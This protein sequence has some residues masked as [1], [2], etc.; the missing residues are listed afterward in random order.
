MRRK[1]LKK[2]LVLWYVKN[3]KKNWWNILEDIIVEKKQWRKGM[4]TKLQGMQETCNDKKEI[5]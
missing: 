1:K 2:H 5:K 3:V 4:N